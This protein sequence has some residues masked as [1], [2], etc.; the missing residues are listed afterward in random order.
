MA[1]M[2]DK[3]FD[4]KAK[5]IKEDFDQRLSVMEK[6]LQKRFDTLEMMIAD[7]ASRIK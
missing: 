6:E 7:V 5:K 2:F 1:G 4:E 3:L